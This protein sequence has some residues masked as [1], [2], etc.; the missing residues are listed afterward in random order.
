MSA[1]I[2]SGGI[3]MKIAYICSPY[4]GDIERN[5]SYAKYLTAEAMA[6]GFAP[7]MPH[8]PQI[9]GGDILEEREKG[10]TAGQALLSCCYAIIVGT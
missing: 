3:E 6:C 5:I 1:K 7:I 10:I 9:L 2:R 8:L 4:R